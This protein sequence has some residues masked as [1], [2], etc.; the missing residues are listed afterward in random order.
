MAILRTKR[1]NRLYVW[2]AS[3]LV[4]CAV[5]Y[6]TRTLTRATLAVR[7]YTVV[8]GS[9][10]STLSTNGKIQP[11][12]N[13]EAHAPFAG[14]IKTLFV[15]EGDRVPRGKLLLTMD[16]ADARA[17][18]ETALAALDG[19]RASADSYSRGG[20]QE[21]RLTLGGDMV[22]AQAELDRARQSLATL[23]KLAASGAAAPSEV[24]AA[25]SRLDNDEASLR[26]LSER[27]TDRYDAGDLTHA[28]ATV[29]E[30]QALVDAARE[31]LSNANVHAPF[32]GTVYSLS[33]SLTEYVQQGDRLLQMADLSKMEVVAYFDEP[34]IGKLHVGQP[35]S[36]TWVAKP[37][38]T[39]HG[40]IWRLPATVITYTTRNVGE[41]YC[42]IDDA[43]DELLPNTN[44]NVTVT[45]AN[46]ADALFV[47]REALHTERGLS[48]VYLVVR[49]RLKRTR[50]TVGT[51]NLTQIQIDSGL[52]PGDVVA[53]GSANAQPLI[54]GAQVDVVP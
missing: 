47:P 51:L 46:V 2:L 37:D 22:R 34:D 30:A 41:V 15:H 35:V 19:A 36:I 24:A 32:A 33:A 42:T 44:V 49:D 52:N 16:D 5:F 28:R 20:T 25:Q 4:V 6:V 10:K 27:K 17:R 9:I 29:A 21:E 53:L 43:S 31:A 13:Y 11:I 14:V 38:R 26:L 12:S 7:T 40:H 54:D 48:Y 8:R 3:A 39:W 1:S 50:V 45:T 18:L 23:K